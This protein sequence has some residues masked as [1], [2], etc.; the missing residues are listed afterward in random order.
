MNSFD[1]SRP[2]TAAVTRGFLQE[3]NISLLPH[4]PL[5]PDLNPIEH[6]WEM[7]ERHLRN[8]RRQPTTMA[9]LEEVLH[10]IWNQISQSNIRKCINIKSRLREIIRRRDSNNSY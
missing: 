5:C 10:Q 2:H 9:D 3:N 4:S 6:V 7:M 8:R 1:N